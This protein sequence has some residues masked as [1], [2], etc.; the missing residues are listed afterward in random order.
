MNEFLAPTAI[1]VFLARE[2]LDFVKGRAKVT[3]EDLRE[4]RRQ[5]DIMGVHVENLKATL[6]LSHKVAS[7]VNV[8]FERIR[9]L[10][11][12]SDLG[13]QSRARETS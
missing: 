3:V 1:I 2:I 4:L 6:Q 5:V 9:N 11:S 10:E 8:A 13:A 12:K 7:D